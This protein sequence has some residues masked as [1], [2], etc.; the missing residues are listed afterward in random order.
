MSSY[1]T[2]NRE[3]QKK[4]AKQFEKLKNTILA[5]FQAKIRWERPR[6]SENKKKSFR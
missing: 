1:P 4:I 3:L 5:Y 6:M 2:R